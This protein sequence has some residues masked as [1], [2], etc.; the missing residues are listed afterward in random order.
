MNLKFRFAL[1]FTSFVAVILIISSVAI[2]ILYYNF[3]LQDFYR[4]VRDEGLNVYRTYVSQK[5]NADSSFRF[6]DQNRYAL[7]SQSIALFDSNYHILLKNPDTFQ[8]SLEK[9]FFQKTRSKGEYYYRYNK[10]ESVGIFI[11]EYNVYVYSSAYD[12]YGLRKLQ[13]IKLILL[14]VLGSSMLLAVLLSLLFVNQAFRPLKK[15]SEQMQRTTELSNAEKV[16]EG[17]GN[18]EIKQIARSYNAMIERLKKAFDY[19]RNFVNHASHE[20]RTPLA[21]MLSQTEAAFNKNLD[22]EGYRKVLTSL[23]ED[24]QEM[25]EL[26]NSLLLLSQYEKM[27]SNEWTLIRIDEVLYETIKTAKK[28][29]PDA[30]LTL[31]FVSIPEEDNLLVKGNETLLRSAI[32]NLIK[33]AYQYSNDRSIHIFLKAGRD[34]IEIS[35]ENKGDLITLEEREK[36]FIPFFRG[37]NSMERKGHGLGLA[38]VQR[39]LDVHKGYVSYESIGNDVN[40]FTI[41]LNK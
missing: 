6:T 11:P 2:Y 36:L 39:I 40:R 25:I 4:R 37:T 26:T 7:V 5:E 13:N 23:K 38:I 16:E 21:S 24:Q 34:K 35:V 31:E 20:L 15:L 33:N 18:D 29:L 27:S 10:R 17:K 14:G 32:R 3:R 41:T 30:L 1:L 22:E 8:V 28:T 9:D 12:R 19:Q